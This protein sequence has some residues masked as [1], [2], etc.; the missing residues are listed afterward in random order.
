MDLNITERQYKNFTWLDINQPT[1][2]H[3]LQIAKNTISN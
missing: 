1:D 2:E 3:F